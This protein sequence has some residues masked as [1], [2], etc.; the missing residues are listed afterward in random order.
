MTTT[1]N[2]VRHSRVLKEFLVSEKGHDEPSHPTGGDRSSCR[3]RTINLVCFRADEQT[4]PSGKNEFISWRT[5]NRVHIRHP[6]AF[7]R[8]ASA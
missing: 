2:V 7:S 5:E 1:V 8:R 6:S 3:E 4:T